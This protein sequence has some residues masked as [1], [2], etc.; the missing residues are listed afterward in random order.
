MGIV[1]GIGIGQFTGPEHDNLRSDS[2][3]G[4]QKENT[5]IISLSVSM[6]VCLPLF[7]S[8]PPSILPFSLSLG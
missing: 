1:I 3:R 2:C 6:P 7:S 8:L 5:A 4:T